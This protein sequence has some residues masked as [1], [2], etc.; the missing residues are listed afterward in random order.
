MPPEI[1]L[2]VLILDDNQDCADS[3]AMLLSVEPDGQIAA[4]SVTGNDSGTIVKRGPV[5][6]PESDQHYKV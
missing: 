1:T 6:S 5:A 2:R 3:L 4:P